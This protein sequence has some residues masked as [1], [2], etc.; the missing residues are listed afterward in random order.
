MLSLEQD[1]IEL[2]VLTPSWARVAATA[3]GPFLERIERAMLVH[4]HPFAMDICRVKDRNRLVAKLAV[5]AGLAKARGVYKAL[6]EIAAKA[7]H[8][9]EK[10]QILRCSLPAVLKTLYKVKPDAIEPAEWK[11]L[12]YKVDKRTAIVTYCAIWKCAPEVAGPMLP[13]ILTMGLDSAVLINSLVHDVPG[14][15][16]LARAAARLQD[17]QWNKFVSMCREARV[18]ERVMMNMD[19]ARFQRS[20]AK[21]LAV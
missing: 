10:R 5:L 2:C 11:R 9:R 16:P 3:T 7:S 14:P 20:E 4:L 8:D 1:E 17:A 6:G 12:C 21:A 15:V 13:K 18:S 19:D